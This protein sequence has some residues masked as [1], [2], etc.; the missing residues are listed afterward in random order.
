MHVQYDSKCVGTVGKKSG[1]KKETLVLRRL[2][3]E[4]DG[5][6][7]ENNKSLLDVAMEKTLSRVVV[8]RPLAADP[9]CA[10]K[11]SS[12]VLGSGQRFD[13]YVKRGGTSSM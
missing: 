11:P 7:A 12:S 3:G 5:E 1:V 13:V 8:K 2:V 4:S 6:D 10:H 9:L